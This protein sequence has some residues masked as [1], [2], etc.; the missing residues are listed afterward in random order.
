VARLKIVLTFFGG[1]ALFSIF[2]IAINDADDPASFKSLFRP[3]SFDNIRVVSITENS[4]I[5]AGST[6][7]AVDCTVEYGTNEQ[8]TNTA[9]D[10]DMMDMVHTEHL[11]TI[12]DLEPSTIYDYRFKVTFEGED[13]YSKTKSFVT[14][15]EPGPQSELTEKHLILP[16]SRIGNII[17]PID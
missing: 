15:P 16:G 2:L 7:R 14:S 4:V 6:N 9:S 17:K 3:I 10:S 11:I 8:F 12:T 13:Y 1:I 5:I